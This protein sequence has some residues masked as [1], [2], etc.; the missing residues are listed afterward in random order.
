[1][2]TGG[3][4]RHVA[5]HLLSGPDDPVLVFNGDVLTGVDLRHLFAVHAETQAAVTLYLT[6]VADPRAFGLVP[7]DADGRVTAFL[8]KPKTAGRDRHRP[9]QRRVLR[10]PAGRSS[11]RS[12]RVARC[13]SNARPSRGLLAAGVRLQGVVDE[14]YWLD[15]GT[16]LAFVQGSADLVRGIGRPRRPSRTHRGLPRDAR[17]PRC[18]ARP[19]LAA[20]R[21][22]GRGDGRART[23][24]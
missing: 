22:S 17:A 16:P 20:G 14:G 8:E 11:T 21:S 10:V 1:M 13:R 18:H 4:I 7:T 19:T 9:D 12:P 24:R 23:P 2:G 6:R 3:A 5:E 15:L